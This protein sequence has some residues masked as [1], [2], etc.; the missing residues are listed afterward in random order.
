MGITQLKKNFQASQYKI[1]ASKLKQILWYFTDLAIYRSRI[2][3]YSVILVY[4]LRIYGAQ[5]GKNVRIKPGIHIKF[6]WK[7]KIGNN[8]WLAD[9]Y[10]ENLDNVVIGD[11]VCVSQ[12]AML[13]TG[14]H[15][16]RITSFDLVIKPI[17]LED[18]VWIGAR[19]IVCPGIKIGSHAVLTL[20]SI[21]TINVE[22]YSIYQGNPAV[23]KKK[24]II[25]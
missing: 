19:A 24:R 1:G 8:C 25:N 15:N 14:S 22:S 5:I 17:V 18:G 7:L 16:Y 20:G 4:I 12:Q 3:P 21:A 23:K 10:I 2:M 13:I 6:P 11:H 9:C